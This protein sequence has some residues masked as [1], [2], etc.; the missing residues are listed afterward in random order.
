LAVLFSALFIPIGPHHAKSLLWEAPSVRRQEQMQDYQFNM[1]GRGDGG[2]NWIMKDMTS[3]QRVP[4]MS[5]VSGKES[6]ND[7]LANS[8]GAVE[9]WINRNAMN[10]MGME[11]G[12]Q[13]YPYAASNPQAMMQAMN[14]QMGASM[15]AQAEADIA[16]AE[17]EKALAGLESANNM[18]RWEG[19][20]IRRRDADAALKFQMRSAAQNNMAPYLTPTNF[21][22]P[23]PLL[24]NAAGSIS[25]T[26][27]KAPA[28]SQTS[29][30]SAVINNPH[31]KI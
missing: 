2:S 6:F 13:P 3:F 17:K 30:Y 7:S 31:N 28:P 12:E 14:S 24:N 22:A 11:Y 25:N 26:K 16:R 4:L 20:Q 18:R 19:E 21:A 29:S 15:A 8:G 9:Q 1:G 10:A 23:K 27:I 5:W